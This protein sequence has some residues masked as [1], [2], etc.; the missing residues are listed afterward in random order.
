MASIFIRIN[1]DSKGAFKDAM[2]EGTNITK[3]VEATRVLE[4]EFMP[5]GKS[6]IPTI[7][8]GNQPSYHT[9]EE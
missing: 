7:F 3:V 1:I 2:V 8:P 5:E 6:L 4:K 9:S